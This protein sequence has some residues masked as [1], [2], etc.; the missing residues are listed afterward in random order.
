MKLVSIG[1]KELKSEGSVGVYGPET[2]RSNRCLQGDQVT[3]ATVAFYSRT[4]ILYK[5]ESLYMSQRESRAYS[6]RISKHQ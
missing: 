6:N 2:T 4:Y 5:R 1:L 3:E